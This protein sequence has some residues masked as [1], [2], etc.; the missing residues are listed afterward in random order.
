MGLWFTPHPHPS[1]DPLHLPNTVAFRRFF[2]FS[3][4]SSSRYGGA[5]F[6][7]FLRVPNTVYID[8]HWILVFVARRVLLFDVCLCL[9][10]WL[11]ISHEKWLASK[12]WDHIS[13]LLWSLNIAN[14]NRHT[15]VHIMLVEEPLRKTH[16]LTCA[17]KISALLCREALHHVI[18]AYFPE[19]SDYCDGWEESSRG[20]T[21]QSSVIFSIFFLSLCPVE[22]VC[23]FLLD[24]IL[25]FCPVVISM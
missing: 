4:A 12:W 15:I 21:F 10:V 19:E 6:I 20:S 16:A 14:K 23:P 1:H 22:S 9:C 18:S 25:F 11:V 13:F 8:I 5:V 3:G 24:T 17:W 7:H 2:L